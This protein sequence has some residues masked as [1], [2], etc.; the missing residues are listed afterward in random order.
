MAT[1]ALW[2]SCQRIDGWGQ[3]MTEQEK[4]QGLKAFSRLGVMMILITVFFLILTY[5]YRFRISSISP[6]FIARYLLL[7]IDL[8]LLILYLWIYLVKTNQFEALLNNEYIK[9]FDDIMSQINSSYLTKRQ[10]KEIRDDLLELLITAQK[11]GRCVYKVT[12][13]TSTFANN[14][15]ESYGKYQWLLIGLVNGFLYTSIFILV[16]QFILSFDFEYFYISS[17]FSTTTDVF[18]LS[19]FIFFFFIQ[20]PIQKI[21]HPEKNDIPLFLF[22]L[23]LLLIS[24]LPIFSP[25]LE[26]TYNSF[27]SKQ[28]NLVPNIYI[29]LIYILII[30]LTILL[31]KIIRNKTKIKLISGD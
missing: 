1:Y 24:S 16:D 14:I 22:S 11:S 4:K 31:K 21:P 25:S 2:N 15:I 8:V 19:I 18:I 28:I 26:K 3:E 5:P 10:K 6:F 7:F 9:S 27:F 30:P 20:I 13:K 17:I 29:L 23:F 12:G